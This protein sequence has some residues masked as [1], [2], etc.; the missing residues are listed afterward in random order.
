MIDIRIRF[1]KIALLAIVI[2]SMAGI[3]ARA[4]S[5][6][7]LNGIVRDSLT[8]EPIP[9]AAVFLKGSDRGGLTDEDGRFKIVTAKNFTA[10]E[11]S[12]MGYESKTVFPKKNGKYDLSID[13]MPIGVKL[14]EVQAQKGE[15]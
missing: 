6:I 15:V 10:I 13:L 11:V 9:Y 5:T 1:N 3:S 14:K 8:H 4:Q 2:M 7:T 12:S